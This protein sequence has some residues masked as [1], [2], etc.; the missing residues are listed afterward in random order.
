MKRALTLCC[1]LPLLTAWLGAAELIGT[2][3][4]TD[5]SRFS[6]KIRMTLSHPG[7]DVTNSSVLVPQA[8]EYRV[9]NGSLPPRASVVGNDAIEPGSTYY[10][11]QYFDAYGALVMSHP[12]FVAGS[13]FDI[14]AARPT[15]IT[16]SNISF[17]DVPTSGSCPGGQY[18]R[19]LS[20]AGVVCSAVNLSG[21][22]SGNLSVEHLDGGTAA[23]A[24]TYWRGDGTW[25]S[26]FLTA[27]ATLDFP[28]TATLTNSDLTVAVSGAVVGD[29]VAVGPPAPP[30][31]NS[32][33]TAFVSDA[34]IVSVRF[35]N[36]SSATIDP[37]SGSF[38][39]TVIK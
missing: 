9:V 35:N 17:I 34:G 22:V 13:A 25:A 5:G 28:S 12:F 24:S 29:P 1:L 37:S 14:G 21:D 19:S 39:V 27:T 6:G 20:A 31:A 36:Y 16:T 7:R 10:W 32:C 8:V 2:I 23:G 38:K 4:K 18:V 33:F 15:T 30:D 26:P 11:A 3:R